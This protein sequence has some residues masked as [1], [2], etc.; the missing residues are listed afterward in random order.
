MKLVLFDDSVRASERLRVLAPYQPEHVCTIHELVGLKPDLVLMDESITPEIANEVLEWGLS[1]CLLAGRVTIALRRKFP[2]VKDMMTDAQLLAYLQE[3]FDPQT[4][5]IE[6]TELPAVTESVPSPEHQE[7]E[8]GRLQS[9]VSTPAVPVRTN[10]IRIERPAVRGAKIIGYVSLRNY[11][12]GAGK[13]GIAFNNA[14]Y[15]VKQ[16]RK[17]LVID[18][19]P[20]G[21]FGVLSRAGQGLTTEHWCNLMNQQRGGAMTERAV[22]DNVERQQP[23][24]FYTITSPSKETMIEPGQFK[25]ILEQ[26]RPYF[27]LIIFDMPAIWDMTTIEMMRM[28]DDLCL[29]GQYDPMQYAEY[30]RSVEIITNPLVVGTTKER[31]NVVLGRGHFG[32]NRDIELEEV[33]QQLGVEHALLIP[34]DPLFQQY[35]NQHKS[36]VLEKPGADCAKAM[37]PL[38]EKQMTDDNLSSNL[39]VL[40]EPIQKGWLNRLFGSNPKPSKKKSK[41]KGVAG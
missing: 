39:P 25:W 16:G 2:R 17:V 34:E 4:N 20:R 30:K 3:R 31:L 24:G 18:I 21:P 28:A 5:E 36:I 37:L 14:A 32:K 10:P 7:P 26:T 13:T 22:F 23:Y 27:D 35:R 8:T 15:M 29:F 6:G 33:K 12:G 40:Y 1:L 41:K 9:G 38:F 11:S 19:D